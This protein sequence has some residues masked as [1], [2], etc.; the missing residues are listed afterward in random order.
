M[1]ITLLGSGDAPGTP[2]VGCS[3]VQCRTARERGISRLRTSV[4]V[5]LKEGKLLIDTSP[6]LRQQLL[7][8]G[9]PRIDAVFWTHGHYDHYIGYGEFYRVQPPPPVYAAEEVMEYCA[10]FFSFLKF[11][12]CEIEPCCPFGILGSEATIFPVNHPPALTYGIRI[13]EAGRIFAYTSDT[14][15]DIPAGSMELL[16]GA[17]LLLVDAIVPPDIHLSKH[18]NYR[19][20]C[21]LAHEVRAREFRCV[22]MSHMIP[23][24]LPHT[25]M[26]MES[27]EI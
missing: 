12:E 27:F 2:K 10:G 22:H 25:A 7:A 8:C 16:Q 1:R 3:C 20:A 21:E 5:E 24:D 6:D 14:R 23:W 19:E 15:R 18:M 17:D 9:S 11:G 4:L 26:D 13:E